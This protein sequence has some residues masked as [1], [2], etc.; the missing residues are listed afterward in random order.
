MVLFLFSTAGSLS[1]QTGKP[2]Q[3]F[4]F[5]GSRHFS[6]KKI[7]EM[8]GLKNEEKL[9]R[10]ELSEKANLFVQFLHDDGYL[11]A[12]IDSIVRPQNPGEKNPALIYLYEGNLFK[13]RQLFIFG[14][15]RFKLQ[16]IRRWMQTKPGKIF[17]PEKLKADVQKLLTEYAKNGFLL[18]K[19]EIQKVDV[20]YPNNAV[21]VVLNIDENNP[22]PLKAFQISGNRTTRKS[23]ITRE[24]GFRP[25]KIVT[26]TR[27]DKIKDRLGRLSFVRLTDDPRVVF[28]PDSA[29]VI[30]LRIQEQN[31]S[32]LNGVLGYN[33][34][35]GD[36]NG[37]VSGQLN[38]QFRNLLGTGRSF[39]A[40]WE[41][42]G[43]VSQSLRLSYEEPYLLGWPLNG[44]FGF[45]QN[46]QDTSFVRRSWHLGFNM[47]L[48]ENVTSGVRF[49]QESVIPDSIGRALY[50][51]PRSNASRLFLSVGFDSR[52]HLWNPTHGI[53]YS[54][55]VDFVEKKIDPLLAGEGSKRRDFRRVS[56]DLEYVRPLWPRHVLFFGFHGRQV[57][58]GN[59]AVP[60][61][62]LYRLGGAK[63][64]RGYRDDQFLGS[65]IAW[66][67]LEYRFILEKDS[68]FGLFMDAAAIGRRKIG[69]AACRERV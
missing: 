64:L 11:S 17:K 22:V 65:Q 53:L 44:E 34:K 48:F 5:R 6:E 24:L 31:S 9:T 21:D 54:T 52:D 58:I 26:Q 51:L 63:N 38:L 14:N 41:K 29:A 66:G 35:Q 25:G 19:I 15:K 28:T 46:V 68:R 20:D 42:R 60:I 13:T 30:Q 3:W 57:K 47:Y 2:S 33:P 69:R 7:R 45:F 49:G 39:L 37:Y 4:R 43:P 36:Q 55:S 61:D 8:T 59:E 16:K 1:A 27:M 67:T 40:L 50:G 32:Q 23:V 62:E 12:R 56:L 10:Q 18:A